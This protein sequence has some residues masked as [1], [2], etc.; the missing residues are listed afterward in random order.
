M[1]V[2]ESARM[3]KKPFSSKPAWHEGSTNGTRR[4]VTIVQPK[5][6]ADHPGSLGPGEHKGAQIGV[7]GGA[8]S[9]KNSEGVTPLPRTR[10]H[11][12]RG[13]FKPRSKRS[14]Y[15]GTQPVSG[16]L[17][18]WDVSCIEERRFPQTNYR[19]QRTEQVHS[20]GA[21]E[22]GGYISCKGLTPEG[23][24][25]GQ[26][27][28]YI[29][30]KRLTPERGLD[31]QAGLKGRLS[32]S[33]NS[34]RT[35]TVLADTLERNKVSIQLPFLQPIVSSESVFED[36]APSSGV[37]ET[38]RLLDD[39]LFG[40]QL[41]HVLHERGSSLSSRINIGANRSSMVCSKPSGVDFRTLSGAAVPGVG[42]QLSCQDNSSAAWRVEK[43]AGRSEIY[44][45]VTHSIRK[46][47]SQSGKDSI[48]ISSRDSP[49]PAVLQSVATAKISASRTLQGLDTHI[50]LDTPLREELRW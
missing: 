47:E 29:S 33:A 19:S 11:N 7:D 42:Y 12:G 49:S 50:V 36:H 25:D 45:K 38:A 5:L 8:S 1:E 20:M 34:P 26:A 39:H 14:S 9:G 16:E 18:F 23:G 27:G 6:G 15:P 4:Q 40:R 10:D 17:Y 13:T 28:G 22:D 43:D 30:C 37:A 41:D 44:P 32:F 21:L 48:F 35:S 31:G 3:G 24:L 46:A 2:N